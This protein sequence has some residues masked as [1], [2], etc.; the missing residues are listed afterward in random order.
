M[1]S[2]SAVPQGLHVDLA[3]ISSYPRDRV[4]AVYL[5]LYDPL[6]ARSI[7]WRILVQCWTSV[8]IE[9]ALE[10]RLLFVLCMFRKDRQYSAYIIDV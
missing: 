10:D 3:E 4:Y 7:I 6:G 8:Y 5:L 2:S 1:T 9:P